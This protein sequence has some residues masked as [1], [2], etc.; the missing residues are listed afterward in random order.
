MPDVRNIERRNPLA[1]VLCAAL[2][3]LVACTGGTDPAPTAPPP[4]PADPL[5]HIARREG[6]V[7]VV[8]QLAIEPERPGIWNRRAI[9]RE[10]GEL[11][12]ALRPGVR[13]VERTAEFP[14][15]ALDVTPAA[16]RRL[17]DHPLVLN[18]TL[19]Q[20]DEIDP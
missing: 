8:V 19:D 16:L 9:A 20:G 2:A 13:V 7:G 12:D 1:L 4:G 17:R 11:V 5:R 3:A 18:I 6:S 14:Q 15:I 10:Q